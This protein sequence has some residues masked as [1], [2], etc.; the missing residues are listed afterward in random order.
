MLTRGLALLIGMLGALMVQPP[1]RADEANS[2]AATITRL[3]VQ[4]AP[5][6]IKE[7]PQW[8]A[9]RKVVLLAFVADRGWAGREAAFAAAAPKAQVVV[10]KDMAAALAATADADAIVGFNPE[11]CSPRIIDNA[12]QLRWIASLA[13]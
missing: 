10:A 11:I 9:P 8:R 13:A 2:V 12:R 6:A 4:E 7:R 1:A 5:Q 3:R